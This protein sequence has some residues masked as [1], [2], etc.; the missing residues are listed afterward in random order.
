MSP[1]AKRAPLPGPVSRAQIVS[2]R[3]DFAHRAPNRIA[4]PFAMPSAWDCPQA[5][6]RPPLTKKKTDRAEKTRRAMGARP[7]FSREKLRGGGSEKNKKATPS[8][9][10]RMAPPG[11]RSCATPQAQGKRR[12]NPIEPGR[13]GWARRPRFASTRRLGPGNA[14]LL[15]P[16]SP[17]P[18]PLAASPAARPARSPARRRARQQ[19]AQTSYAG[20]R[21]RA[22]KPG[23]R[24]RKAKQRRYNPPSAEDESAAA[25]FIFR[26]CWVRRGAERRAPGLPIDP[27]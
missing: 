16:P 9:A 21:A 7:R 17:P 3:V 10:L 24:R 19:M 15:P 6:P 8:K 25:F 12:S 4:P 11:L 2:N 23:G 5:P 13:P 22:L 26:A 14:P 1:C 18:S 27:G 20:A